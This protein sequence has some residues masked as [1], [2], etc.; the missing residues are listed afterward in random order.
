MEVEARRE[1]RRRIEAASA[2]G[3]TSQAVAVAVAVATRVE[4]RVGEGTVAAGVAMEGAAKVAATGVANRAGAQEEAAMREAAATG[5]EVM[6]PLR[7]GRGGRR[8]PQR[9][10]PNRVA[11]TRRSPRCKS[12]TRQ[13]WPSSR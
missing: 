9:Q 13:D 10:S 11:A 3:R 4:T 7:R 6:A 5:P 12:Y 8:P 1:P 2:L